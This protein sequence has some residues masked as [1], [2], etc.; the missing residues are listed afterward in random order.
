ML[1]GLAS[2]KQVIELSKYSTLLKCMMY[3]FSFC[4]TL[5]YTLGNF[6]IF[7]LKLGSCDDSFWMINSGT[8]LLRS[9][10]YLQS[11]IAGYR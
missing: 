10:N 3:G 4:S 11:N 9:V 6:S 8:L 5:C 1:D 2:S 7:K